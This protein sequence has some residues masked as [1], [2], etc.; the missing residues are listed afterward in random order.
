MLSGKVL[1]N[2]IGAPFDEYILDQLDI[3]SKKNALENRTNEDILYLANKTSW[4]RLVSSIRI[5][6]AG[7]QTFQQFYA[8]LFDGEIVPGDYSKPESLAQNW[9]LQAG[10]S[11]L[12][13]NQ[14]NLRF[15]LGPNGAYGLGGLQ[16]GYRPM[17][18]I[19][20]LTIDSKGAL[21]SLREASINFK[22][23]NI[24]QLN[25]VEALY[26]R[27]GYTMLLEWGHVNY[28]D[29]KEK[30]QTNS[31]DNTPLDI[32]DTT[33]FS[34]KE[35]IQQAITRKN[36]R[37]N[38]NYDGML[39]TVTNFYYSFN[40]D[41]GFDCN[42]KLVG[43]GSVIDTV[44]INQTFTMPRVLQERIKDQQAEI[45]ERDRI[46]VE[47]E[48]KAKDLAAR[49]TRGLIAVPPPE[50]KNLDGIKAIYKAVYGQDPDATFLSTISFPAVQ[51]SE[52][53]APFGTDYFYKVNSNNT[54]LNDDLN[55]G[56]KVGNVYYAPRAG[57]FLN[58]RN[59]WQFIPAGV[60][61]NPQ[62]VKLNTLLIEELA[63]PTRQGYADSLIDTSIRDTRISRNDSLYD[64]VS[65]KLGTSIDVT[66]Y[67]RVNV[68]F[69]TGVETGGIW[70]DPLKD[71]TSSTVVG[72]LD[73]SLNIKNE[74]TATTD[75]TA[76]IFGNRRLFS[77]KLKEDTIITNPFDVQLA[78]VLDGKQK[79][80][81]FVINPQGKH[82]REEY[83]QG[84]TN[85]FYQVRTVTV[86]DLQFASSIGDKTSTD[87]SV[88][89]HSIITG[90]VVKGDTITGT[91][92]FN[93]SGLI[94]QVLPLLP[95]TGAPTPALGTTIDSTGNTVGAENGVTVAQ[96]QE[97]KQ[98]NSAL[99]AMLIA[100]MT[101][102]QSTPYNSTGITPIDF[103]DN[104]KILF[105]SGVLNGIFNTT[106]KQVS[107]AKFNVLDYALKGFNSNLMA[108]KTLYNEILDV[109][110][111][112]LCTGYRA[113]Y[114]FSPGEVSSISDAQK[115]V[116]I[117]FGYLLAFMNSM[118]LLYE[119]KDK[120]STTTNSNDIK[121][122]FYIDFHP[123]YNFCLTSPKQFSVDP[124]KVLI[125]FQA[126]LE[127]Y[128]SLFP[129]DIAK[130]LQNELFNPEKDNVFSS[131]LPSFK[132]NTSL[133]GKT[134]EILLNTQYLLEL[135]DQF[136]KADSEGAVYFKPFLDRVLDD[137]NK[138]TGGFNLFRVAYRD[139]SN[140]VIIKD[141]QRVPSKGEPTCIYRAGLPA[142]RYELN[143]FG[144]G[145][146]IR[147]MEFRTNMNTPMSAMIAISAQAT[148]GNQVANAQDA[149]AIGAY[150]TGYDDAFMKIKLNS[151]SNANNGSS[152][153]GTAPPKKT[154]ATNDLDTAKKFNAYVKQ[155]YY[156]G[157]PTKLQTDSA[158]SY[159]LNR[160]RI[161]KAEDINTQS[162]PF[163]PANLSINIDGISGILMG[164]AFTVPSNRLPA[165]LRGTAL[166]PKVGFVVVGLTQTLQNNEWTTRIRGQMI[167]IGD[168][169]SATGSKI[170]QVQGSTGNGGYR[171]STVST[172]GQK[173]CPGLYPGAGS[174]YSCA[175]QT[176]TPFD[177]AAFKRAYPNYV[178]Q[179]GTSN[180][181]LKAAGL[182]P[183]TESDI[184]DDTSK[185]K[186]D[187][188]NYGNGTIT[189][190]A[191]NF[192]IHHT[193]GGG[194]ADG[195]YATFYSR[196]LPAQYVI[197]QQG[198]IHR[199]LPDG[200]LGWHAGPDYNRSSIGVEVIGANDQDIAARSKTNNKAQ[201]I[202]A[203]RLAQYLGFK[204][205][206]VV[207]HGPISQGT[208]EFTEGKTIV[209]Y[210]KTL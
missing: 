195:T 72:L 38:G 134:M 130:D 122:Y 97:A 204:K 173:T 198:G 58:H 174:D 163:I 109:N 145:S 15:G 102:G 30:F 50:A 99:H 27:L 24:V 121:P 147:D 79:F 90:L 140:T 45:K 205:N 25:I 192:V 178:F 115:P 28:F 22:V 46:K 56:G 54:A 76:L 75:V 6:P 94:D 31:V 64:K 199:F 180:I 36:E 48:N 138:A 57:L 51:T 200:A 136:L 13:N 183:L 63:D 203:A 91:V 19:E 87:A 133:Q 171:G 3:R 60:A 119:A 7:N 127:E 128:K 193:G 55:I 78:Y 89:I 39:G 52:E 131:K 44:R 100:N 92:T 29:N 118:C 179:K 103:Q 101:K 33:K 196:G 202:A 41:G 120:Q 66:F 156:S 26:F 53:N 86:D 95:A 116:Y 142:N 16:Q 74:R 105:E 186:F 191:A 189:S 129:P 164:N 139:D 20:S 155:V 159:Y 4:T 113:N 104:T 111:K 112:D 154:E 161:S 187:I 158:I 126:T 11:Q 40:Q 23:W 77:T 108:G 206:Q 135:A 169:I 148:I 96:A 177:T 69:F 14:T 188:T 59:G 5:A 167:K 184:I 114:T 182:T 43:L 150:N 162:A 83:I 170:A 165:S 210:I 146:I 84:L 160:L 9:I 194:T 81:Q 62:P 149:T 144:K 107:P 106:T 88:V 132:T 18:G 151:T 209:D 157:D 93:D 141:D 98:Y 152:G 166:E 117:K 21:G 201:L 80:I 2:V 8:N 34:G 82:T 172:N 68:N 35:D 185:N 47:N 10:T 71:Y 32:F 12:I 181:N 175:R 143:I 65:I 153:T 42:I 73:V 168:D 207:G 137:I 190:P 70:R 125:P 85:W 49:T 17:P 208:K 110:F 123:E 67:P 1:S 61:S 124:Y 37:S 176:S 197:D